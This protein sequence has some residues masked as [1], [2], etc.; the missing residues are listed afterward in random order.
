MDNCLLLV[1]EKIGSWNQQWGTQLGER[2]EAG[3]AGSC[4]L[5]CGGEG[6][7]EVRTEE[8]DCHHGHL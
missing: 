1:H 6:G 7:G 5:E 8:I 3:Q 4:C 2:C